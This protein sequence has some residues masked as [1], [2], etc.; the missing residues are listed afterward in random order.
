MPTRPHPMS[1]GLRRL[2]KKLAAYTVARNGGVIGPTRIKHTP[3]PPVKP[4][5]SR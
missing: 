1:L 4:R 2:I 5:S 3:G